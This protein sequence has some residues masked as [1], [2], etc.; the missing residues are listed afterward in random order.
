MFIE[1]ENDEKYACFNERL[2]K[3]FGIQSFSPVASCEKDLDEMKALAIQI[4]ED[5]REQG[6]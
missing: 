5:Y 6:I 4:M 1:I 2:P 3:V